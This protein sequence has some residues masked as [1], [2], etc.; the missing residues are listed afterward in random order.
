MTRMIRNITELDNVISTLTIDGYS[1]SE[2]QELIK[3]FNDD[4]D[5]MGDLDYLIRIKRLEMSQCLS[6]EWIVSKLKR[7]AEGD[8]DIAAV[9]ALNVLSKMSEKR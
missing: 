2:I 1:D 9:K 3:P 6:K 5:A 8:D 7:I 4:S